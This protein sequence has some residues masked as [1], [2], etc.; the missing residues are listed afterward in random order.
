[1]LASYCMADEGK[2]EGNAGSLQ[3]ALEAVRCFLTEAYVG[4]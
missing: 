3:R 2:T 4:A 1:M